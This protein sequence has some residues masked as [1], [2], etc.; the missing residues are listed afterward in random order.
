MIFGFYDQ[1]ESLVK[2]GDVD[3]LQ[4]RCIVKELERLAIYESWLE[5]QLKEVEAAYQGKDQ[6]LKPIIDRIEDHK[7]IING[8]Q[9]AERTH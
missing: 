1:V 5:G 9:F 6:Q 2:D 8:T 7:C 3:V 4:M